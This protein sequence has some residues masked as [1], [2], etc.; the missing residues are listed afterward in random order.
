VLLEDAVAALSAGDLVG[1]PTETF[2]GIAAD[3]ESQPA[4]ERLI[5]AKGRD[6][7]KP[8]A[9]IAP[10]RAAA[11]AFFSG[12]PPLAARLAEHLWPGPLTLVLPARAGLHPALYGPEGVGVRVSS[13]PIAAELASRFGRAI[14]ATSANLA[15]AQPTVSADEV[16]RVFGDKLKV[17]L[18]AE[19]VA[20]GPPSTVVAVTTHGL[21]ILRRGAISE[22]AISSAVRG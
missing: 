5:A 3:P 6:P 17:I 19:G 15:G 14:T 1:F 21:R 16:R 22:E 8:I 10:D 2:Y 11:F 20:G 13:H 12:V 7:D 4:M 18:E 9:L